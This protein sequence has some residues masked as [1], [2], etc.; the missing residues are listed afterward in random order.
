NLITSSFIFPKRAAFAFPPLA[1]CFA[2]S[3]SLACRFFPYIRPQQKFNLA[4]DFKSNE[5]ENVIY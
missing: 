5:T 2:S 3:T 1:F 4:I